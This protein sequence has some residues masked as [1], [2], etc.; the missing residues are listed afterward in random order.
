MPLL[1]H[2]RLRR[3]G[4]A[5]P[6]PTLLSGRVCNLQATPPFKQF[7][8]TMLRSFPV[9]LPLRQ[10]VEERV[11]SRIL[12]PVPRRSYPQS[13]QGPVPQSLLDCISLSHSQSPMIDFAKAM[14]RRHR[15]FR[16]PWTRAQADSCT[17]PPLRGD[18][19][20][21]LEPRAPSTS[22]SK[23]GKKIC[24]FPS[25]NRWMKAE[26]KIRIEVCCKT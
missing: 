25:E 9:P 21:A 11:G 13:R 4:Q 17:A 14:M 12:A 6:D 23:G 8:V 16:A 24:Q 7:F 2:L 5:V 3:R 15:W 18:E 1:P 10:F 20:A 19:L 26:D 22:R